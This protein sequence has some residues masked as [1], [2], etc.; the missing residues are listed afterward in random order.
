MLA[1]AEMMGMSGPGGGPQV[2]I[3][4]TDASGE[5]VRSMKGPAQAGLNRVVW[6]LRRDGFKQPP[7]GGDP[8]MEMLFG[9]GP[10]V[11]PGTY[12]MEISL[13]DQ[14]VEG[15]IEILPD[16]RSSATEADYRAKWAAILETGALQEAV[17]DAVVQI[18]ETRADIETIVKKAQAAQKVEAGQ[19]ATGLH[20]EPAAEA[21]AE[22]GEQAAQDPYGR[23]IEM[24]GEISKKLTALEGRLRTPPDVKG[25]VAQDDAMAEVSTAMMRLTSSWDQPSSADEAYVRQ[26]RYAI[27][28]ILVDLRALFEGETSELRSLTRAAG[29][30]LLP[31]VEGPH[32]H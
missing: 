12:A 13:G 17:T 26:T 25:I 27:E 30:E 7:G 8:M 18:I 23:L 22:E 16:P 29:I 1:M 11:P 5:K 2:D 21:P 32:L 31:E 24:G 9:G 19:E 14:V 10:E 3:T 20:E 28:K 6:N 4:I 15:T